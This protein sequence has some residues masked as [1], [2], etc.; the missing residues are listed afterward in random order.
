[1]YKRH[2]S[3]NEK[4]IYRINGVLNANLEHGTISFYMVKHK[5]SNIN[6]EHQQKCTHAVKLIGTKYLLYSFRTFDFTVKTERGDVCTYI[7][8]LKNCV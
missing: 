5:L 3:P 7:N 4:K 8:C 2:L 1:M 6:F